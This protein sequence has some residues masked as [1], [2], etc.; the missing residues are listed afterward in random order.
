[1]EAQ[2]TNGSIR[3]SN[4][5]GDAFY[6]NQEMTSNRPSLDVSDATKEKDKTELAER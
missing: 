3:D 1:M 4:K 2:T 6:D 5:I